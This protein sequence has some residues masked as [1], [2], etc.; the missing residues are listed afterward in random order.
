LVGSYQKTLYPY[1]DNNPIV[2]IDPK[3]KKPNLLNIG[4]EITVKMAEDNVVM[5]EQQLINEY[6]V[7]GEFSFNTQFMLATN[8]VWANPLSRNALLFPLS[9]GKGFTSTA[10]KATTKIFGKTGYLK[11]V[12]MRKLDGRLLKDFGDFIYNQSLSQ[13][14]RSITNYLNY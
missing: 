9:R 14:K 11:W 13:L 4:M 8:A 6:L 12:D 10:G 2:K 7:T 5:L 3:G 1:A